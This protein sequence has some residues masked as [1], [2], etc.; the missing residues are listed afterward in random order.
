MDEYLHPLGVGTY[1]DPQTESVLGG[2]CCHGET[3]LE[4]A[5]RGTLEPAEGRVVLG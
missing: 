3:R 4:E 1:S 2:G 5:Q